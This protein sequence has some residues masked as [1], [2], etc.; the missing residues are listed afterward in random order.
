M[1]LCCEGRKGCVQREL[2]RY[3]YPWPEIGSTYFLS[4]CTAQLFFGQRERSFLSFPGGHFWI[5]QT[6]YC[7][8]MSRS[9]T[10]FIDSPD[11]ISMTHSSGLR[12]R[13]SGSL[14]SLGTFSLRH[15]HRRP[16][17]HS[18]TAPHALDECQGYQ[19]AVGTTRMCSCADFSGATVP[20]SLSRA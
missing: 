4:T 14:S 6:N 5:S 8:R 12:G 2:H 10:P 3:L 11:P 17:G 1:W 16:R 18:R 19:K 7:I 15:R 20:F 13:T 9:K